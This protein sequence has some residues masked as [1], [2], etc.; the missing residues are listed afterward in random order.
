MPKTKFNLEYSLGHTSPSRLWNHLHTDAGLESW[1]AD[2]V[3]QDGKQF[4]FH[5]GEA[6]Q[7]ASLVSLRRDVYVRYR[8]NDDQE[9]TFFEMRISK[10]EL[11]DETTLS[12]TDYADNDDDQ[13]ELTDLW[14]QQVDNLKRSLGV[15]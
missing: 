6:S 5:W 8:W 10:S 11:T 15:S 14:N 3:E 13:E 12:V 4:T 7:R 1:F 9:R 2:R